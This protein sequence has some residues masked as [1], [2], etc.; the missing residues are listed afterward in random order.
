MKLVSHSPEETENI[1][2]RIGKQLKDGDIVALYGDLGSGKTTL[3]KGI[4]SAFGIDRRDVVSPSF[5]IISEYPGEVAF[6]HVDLYRTSGDEDLE[7]IGFW[8][9]VGSDGITVI[10]WAEK[11]GESLPAHTIT[12][13]LTV[14]NPEE[15]EI[16]IV[17]IDEENRD[18]LQNR[19]A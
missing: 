19:Q 13:S 1:G 3:A 5:T 12:V 7:G 4:A 17:G 10:E 15:R 14:L 11:A 6:R 8:E 18:H 9:A 16:T 2:L